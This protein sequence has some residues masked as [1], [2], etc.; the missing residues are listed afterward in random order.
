MNSIQRRQDHESLC[1]AL[2]PDWE[3]TF[4]RNYVI[5]WTRENVYQGR[6]LMGWLWHERKNNLNWVLKEMMKDE[7]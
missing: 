4:P 7:E 1:R 3:Q 2:T 5:I 6:L